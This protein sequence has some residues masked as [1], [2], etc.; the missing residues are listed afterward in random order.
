MRNRS[1]LILDMTPAGEFREPA[2]SGRRK[3]PFGVRLGRTAI[4]VAFMAAGLAVAA[5]ALWF[6]L[7]LIPV[8]F[9][10][11]LV[12]WAAFRFHLWRN[13]MTVRR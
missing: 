1:D 13:A 3:T 9:G 12:A 8:A 4:I 6:A 7:I 5:L 11:G 10:A 2:S